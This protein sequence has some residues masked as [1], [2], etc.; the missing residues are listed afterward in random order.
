VSAN[1]GKLM[2]FWLLTRKS[3]L[4]EMDF[5]FV[6]DGHITPD[7]LAGR[8]NGLEVL[9]CVQISRFMW[10][11]SNITSILTG[12]MDDPSLVKSFQTKRRQ[13]LGHP[14]IREKFGDVLTGK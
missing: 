13:L 4:R 6:R 5:V 2:F 9:S 3:I 8:R 12:Q 14:L 10:H 7:R 11:T 1:A